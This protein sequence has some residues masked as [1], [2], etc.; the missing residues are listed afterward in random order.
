MAVRQF[1]GGA[2][3]QVARRFSMCVRTVFGQSGGR[4]VQES[5]PGGA[6]QVSPALERWVEWK[7]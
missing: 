3:L 6:S 7:Q 5:S 4:T 2:A 1:L